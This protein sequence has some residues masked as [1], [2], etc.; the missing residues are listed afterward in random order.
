MDNDLSTWI[1]VYP[2]GD[3]SALKVVEITPSESHE[4]GDYAIA[5]RKEFLGDE[6][7]AC[8]YA[9]DLAKQN[10]LS[11]EGSNGDHDYLD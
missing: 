10:G 11:Y 9:R 3:K 2:R 8:E 4:K 1:I 6:A 5:S 7:A